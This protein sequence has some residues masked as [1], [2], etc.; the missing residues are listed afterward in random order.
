MTEKLVKTRKRVADVG[1][2]FTPRWLVDEVIETLP[3]SLFEDPHKTFIDP[4]CGDGNF[5]VVVLEQK[6]LRG[7]HPLQALLTIH[8][9]DIMPDN[10]I[11]CRQRLFVT[12]TTFIDLD[13]S[14]ER[15]LFKKFVKRRTL[16]R[17]QRALRSNIQHGDTLRFDIEDIFS[18][19]PS[20]EL[21][22]FRNKK[23]DISELDSGG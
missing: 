21:L 23:D 7:S 9:V 16:K 13:Y 6:V 3:E 18:S 4:T 12:V 10:V 8:G 15:N 17:I 19:S 22:N 11:E 1:E 5:L 20:K 14:R 2:V